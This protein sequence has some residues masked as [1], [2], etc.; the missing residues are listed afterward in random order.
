MAEPTIGTAVINRVAK[1]KNFFYVHG[2]VMID[3]T[4]RAIPICTGTVLYFNAW[5]ND[6]DDSTLRVVVNSDDG[7][8]DT[9]NGSVYCQSSQTDDV[10]RFEAGVIM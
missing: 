1:A 7:T 5:N 4:A 8:E 6:D 2:Q 3:D 10:F 9:A